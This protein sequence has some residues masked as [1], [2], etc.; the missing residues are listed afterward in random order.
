M[1]GYCTSGMPTIPKNM[2]QRIIGN[3]CDN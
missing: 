3:M 1:Q 2:K